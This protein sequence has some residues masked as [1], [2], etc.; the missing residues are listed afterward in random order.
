MFVY[1]GTSET[2]ARQ[3]LKSGIQ[4]RR[5]SGSD[6]NWKHTV[7]SNPDFVY[8]TVAYAPYYAAA[9][10][11]M[12][13][14]RPAV[15]QIDLDALDQDRLFPDE[16]FIEQAMRGKPLGPSEELKKR[17]RYVIEHIEGYRE[18]WKLSLENLGTLCFKGVVPASAI[19]KIV[20]FDA[21]KNPGVALDMLDP[22]V[23][24]ANYKWCGEKY[25][26]L[27][28]WFMGEEIDPV[29]IGF[30]MPIAADALR[31]MPWTE[32]VIEITRKQLANRTRL[33]VLF[34]RQIT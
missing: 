1:H 24:L 28:R 29:L 20:A 22:L 21:S 13:R 27:T 25:R 23:S 12:G 6:G 4:P 7:K 17:N 15:I 18:N 5:L 10:T 31:N 16:D 34:D 2:A 19:T 3:A 9:V 30:S 8:L 33:E 26:A 11:D 14:E 32:E